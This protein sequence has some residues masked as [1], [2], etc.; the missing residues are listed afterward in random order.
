MIKMNFD[1][2]WHQQP[3][4]WAACDAKTLAR[5]VWDHKQAEIDA[6]MR[7]FY[8]DDMTQEQTEEYERNQ[9][10]APNRR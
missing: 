7:K 2:F 1:D 8:P 10:T 5:K 4:G 6:L 3:F 9:I